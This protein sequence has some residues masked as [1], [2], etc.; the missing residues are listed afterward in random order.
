MEWCARSVRR[1][2]SVNPLSDMDRRA[3]PYSE[4]KFMRAPDVEKLMRALEAHP[5]AALLVCYAAMTF[6]CGIRGA[7][8]HRLADCPDDIMLDDETI[9]ISMPKG[10]TK[11]IK[12][13]M[14][15]LTDNALAWLMAYDARSNMN[16]NTPLILEK[17]TAVARQIGVEY[18]RNVA[19]HTFVTMH[20][21]AFEDAAKTESMVGTSAQM[22]AKNYQGL[23]SHKEAVAYFE[24][25]PEK[26]A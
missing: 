14:V 10:W 26:K 25:M 16:R 22:R 2:V 18:P 24:I 12:P 7:E 13:R 9:R 1:Y 23:V 15:R 5:D 11:G 3:V 17:I 8:I 21:A 6:F 20:C 19:R 4:P